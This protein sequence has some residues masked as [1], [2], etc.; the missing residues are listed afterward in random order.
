VL[1]YL[2]GVWTALAWLGAIVPSV[3][4]DGVYDFVARHRHQIAR[5][6][7]SCLLPTPE[8]RAR[9]V[10]WGEAAVG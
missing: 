9:F 10:D 7:A 3:I 8:Q 2:G 5:R 6:D 1:R 4:R